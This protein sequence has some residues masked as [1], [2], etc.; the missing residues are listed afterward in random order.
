MTLN[1]QARR[2][3]PNANASPT[4]QK[5]IAKKP[6]P[7]MEGVAIALAD[8]V[9]L[10]DQPSMAADVLAGHGFTLADFKGCE[11][12]DLKVIRKLYRTE[13]VLRR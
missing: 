3:A 2:P 5:K 10:H 13:Y 12:Y 9:R 7:F 11:P 1:I 4:S 6:D 8:L